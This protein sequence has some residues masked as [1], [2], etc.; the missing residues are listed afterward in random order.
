MKSKIKGRTEKE[1][2]RIEEEK[3]IRKREK[4]KRKR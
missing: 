2:M 3:K 1:G 4:E